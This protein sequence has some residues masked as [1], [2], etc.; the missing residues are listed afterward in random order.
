MAHWWLANLWSMNPVIAISWVFWV[1]FSICCHEL[2]HGY[3]A[4]RK[5]DDT[6]IASGHMTWNPVVH[7]GVFS[8]IMFLLSGIAWGAMPVS[9]SRLR[10][11]HADA[12]VAFAGPV[13]NLIFFVVCAILCITWEVIPAFLPKEP[14]TN[15]YI[16]LMTGSALNLVLFLFNLIPVPPL[17]GSRVLASF[18]PAYSNFVYSEKGSIAMLIAFVVLFRFVGDF[19]FAF[20][21]GVAGVVISFGV[22]LF[23]PN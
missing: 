5:G 9:P 2:G 11:R 1:I 4:I 15:I 13:V 10:G 17:D 7:M 6:P 21:L 23:H 18:V 3:A 19:I 14:H 16:F 12:Y 20:G 22:H 8:L